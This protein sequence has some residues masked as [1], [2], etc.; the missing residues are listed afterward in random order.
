[1]V[2]I[3]KLTK[4]KNLTHKKYQLC[5]WVLCTTVRAHVS[6][7]S[8]TVKTHEDPNTGPVFPRALLWRGRVS[9]LRVYL[10]WPLSQ[11]VTSCKHK[12]RHLNFDLQPDYLR[13]QS[14]QWF[15]PG[16]IIL[17]RWRLLLTISKKMLG[18]H[19]FPGVNSIHE[20]SRVVHLR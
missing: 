9:R 12:A 2:I 3:Y 16:V 4:P 19:Q 6:G 20:Q 14:R 18:G 7:S 15:A 13:R 11:F 1:M 8:S 5:F 10:H 17:I